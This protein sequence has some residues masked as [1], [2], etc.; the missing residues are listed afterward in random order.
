M[1]EHGLENN[2][3]LVVIAKAMKDHM[4][5]RKHSE[6][7]GYH[8]EMIDSQTFS[9]WLVLRCFGYETFDIPQTFHVL[10]KLIQSPAARIV[11]VRHC[12]ANEVVFAQ[13]W[14]FG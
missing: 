8:N 7:I 11:V 5:G 1:H 12:K 13:V 9:K 3:R 4:D 14:K 2:N 10:T 6:D